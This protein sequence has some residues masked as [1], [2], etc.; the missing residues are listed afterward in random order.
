LEDCARGL[1]YRA[2]VLSGIRHAQDYKDC[3]GEPESGWFSLRSQEVLHD[4]R[5]KSF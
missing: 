2:E 5:G 1:A 4:L 3:L